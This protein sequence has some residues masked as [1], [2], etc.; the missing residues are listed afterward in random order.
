MHSSYTSLCVQKA[1][2]QKKAAKEIKQFIFYFFGGGGNKAQC[3]NTENFQLG[4]KRQ[5][6]QYVLQY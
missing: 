4:K 6:K 5:H 2:H 3:N 1:T